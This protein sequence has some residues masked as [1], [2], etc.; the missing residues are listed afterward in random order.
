MLRVASSQ[1]IR[2]F[3]SLVILNRMRASATLRTGCKL[4]RNGGRGEY[5]R[6]VA[7]FRADAN[8]LPITGAAHSDVGSR[9]RLD[10]FPQKRA[11]RRRYDFIGISQLRV[12]GEIEVG[13]IGID[14]QCEFSIDD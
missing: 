8:P 1:T 3:D 9:K 11:A 6:R 12:Q 4:R 14:L 5:L 13:A 10:C 2:L 7:D